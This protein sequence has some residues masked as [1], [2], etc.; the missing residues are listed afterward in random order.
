[1]KEKEETIRLI[2]FEIENYMKISFA[3]FSINS[4]Y[5]EIG[6][7]NEA[8]KSSLINA[9]TSTL[10]Y[11]GQNIPEPIQKN[12]KYS[13]CTLIFNQFVVSKRISREGNISLTI[14]DAKTNEPIKAPQRFLDT[15]MSPVILD[16][17]AFAEKY[18]NKKRLEILF[19]ITG[20]KDTI[21][22]LDNEKSNLYNQRTEENRIFKILTGKLSGHTEEPE[23]EVELKSSSDLMQKLKKEQERIADINELEKEVKT[24]ESS[25]ESWKQSIEQSYNNVDIYE[26]K[27]KELKQ[28][29][30]SEKDNIQTYNNYMQTCRENIKNFEKQIELAQ[31]SIINKIESEL[32][33][34]DEYNNNA[35]AI[36]ERNKLREQ[37]SNVKTEI[38][39]L[40]KSIN[41]I[42]DK[43]IDILTNSNLPYGLTIQDGEIKINNLS[44]ENQSTSQALKMA[45]EIGKLDKSEMKIMTIGWNDLDKE[46]RETVINFINENNYIAFIESVC[47]EPKEN[48]LFL[49]NGE[50]K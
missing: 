9:I 2:S 23:E 48:M 13:K 40:S 16:P 4:N 5:I 8:G 43:K 18:D 11:K 39:K 42:D 17:S 28:L 46:S 10:G 14:K 27:I 44:W 22:N 34:I 31:P 36:Q 41:K 6:G 47:E 3:E 37:I 7:K 45:M 21:E 32:E 38:K 29:I 1:M 12:R 24:N 49:D 33:T 26:A 25:V 50:I 15:L 30:V 19:Q 35:R 20:I